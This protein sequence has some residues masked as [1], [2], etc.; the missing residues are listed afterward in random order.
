[1]LVCFQTEFHLKSSDTFEQTEQEYPGIVNIMDKNCFDSSECSNVRTV[2]LTSNEN[3]GFGI[4]IICS[5]HHCELLQWQI[6]F[7]SL[8]IIEHEINKKQE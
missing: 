2:F 8:L 1:M 5:Y 7:V 3:E 6:L 4:S